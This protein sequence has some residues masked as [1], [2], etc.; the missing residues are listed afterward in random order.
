MVIM[1]EGT[2]LALRV[3]L[4]TGRDRRD[5]KPAGRVTQQKAGGEVGSPSHTHALPESQAHSHSLP[6]QR[7]LP[8]G[9]RGRS[10][11]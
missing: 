1:G 6:R 11:Q 9:T 4:E 10:T 7:P 5:Q 3:F 2:L 8:G